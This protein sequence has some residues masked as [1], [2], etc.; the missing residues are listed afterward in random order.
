MNNITESV[1]YLISGVNQTEPYFD[2][3]WDYSY[4]PCPVAGCPDP[5]D[6]DAGPL[7]EK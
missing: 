2:L 5:V 6:P 4:E 3:K 1:T 7:E